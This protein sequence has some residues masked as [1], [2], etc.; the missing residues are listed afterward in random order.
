MGAWGVLNCI[1]ELPLFVDANKSHGVLN[2]WI[3]ASSMRCILFCV[4]A[5][6]LCV[7]M[8]ESDFPGFVHMYGVVWE[9]DVYSLYVE[10]WVIFLFCVAICSVM[11]TCVC[12][13]NMWLSFEFEFAQSEVTN[14][15]ELFETVSSLLLCCVGAAILFV[16]LGVSMMWPIHL[17]A[18]MSILLF[19]L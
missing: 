8:V 4:V 1:S 18:V 17:L 7:I 11:E 5:V 12:G 14:F 13:Q 19:F 2:E 3:G 16:S 15:L 9:I 10:R 6:P